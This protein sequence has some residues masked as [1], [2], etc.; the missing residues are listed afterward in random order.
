MENEGRIGRRLANDFGGNRERLIDGVNRSQIE[1]L[2]KLFPYK[3]HHNPLTR[4]PLM[5]VFV[6]ILAI[7]SIL[8]LET[9]VS[10]TIII[11]MIYYGITH[12]PST[13]RLDIS[14]IKDDIQ[15]DVRSD[16]NVD[17]KHRALETIIYHRWGP[18]YRRKCRKYRV[19][20]SLLVQAMDLNVIYSDTIELAKTRLKNR[21]VGAKSVNV[22]CFSIVFSS[23]AIDTLA[24]GYLILEEKFRD[25]KKSGFTLANM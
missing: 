23:I 10:W 19:S 4:H 25:R 15:S 18:V 24:I 14:D 2:S 3:L 6:F 12:V 13:S 5:L 16:V 9:P 8:Y 21:L 11:L 22:D 17:A 7:A 20:L 1:S